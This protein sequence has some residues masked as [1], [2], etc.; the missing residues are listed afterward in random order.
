MKK[1]NNKKKKKK[2]K[3]NNNSSN[4]GKC[5]MKFDYDLS[6]STP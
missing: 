5:R 3:S 6:N 1:K 2:K 4:Y